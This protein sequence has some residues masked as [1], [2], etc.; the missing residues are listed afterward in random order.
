MTAQLCPSKGTNAGNYGDDRKGRGRRLR[1]LPLPLPPPIF[2]ITAPNTNLS[3]EISQHDTKG[4]SF[5]VTFLA[6]NSPNSGC[7]M[8]FWWSIRASEPLRPAGG[9][10]FTENDETRLFLSFSR[11]IVFASRARRGL[12]ATSPGPR[13]TDPG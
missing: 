11:Q 1:L 13:Q 2:R 12:L 9:L 8:G 3:L 6:I 5:C 4:A 7:T 10:A